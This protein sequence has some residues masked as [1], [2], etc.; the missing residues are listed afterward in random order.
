MAFF[1]ILEFNKSLG[2]WKIGNQGNFALL[3]N[4]LIQ[5]SVIIFRY[6]CVAIFGY[7]LRKRGSLYASPFGEGI[8]NRKKSGVLPNPG[9]KKNQTSFLKKNFILYFVFVFWD[10]KVLQCHWCSGYILCSSSWAAEGIRK[11]ISKTG[12]TRL[13]LRATEV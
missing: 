3:R 1:A 6:F 5:E 9:K 12:R 13:R 11:T 2:S 10:R 7:I 4:L 8:K